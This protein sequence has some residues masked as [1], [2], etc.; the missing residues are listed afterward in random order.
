MVR[1]DLFNVLLPICL[2]IHSL[3][4]P[5]SLANGKPLQHLSFEPYHRHITA[6][7][8]L[9]SSIVHH[10]L[11]D[12]KGLLWFC[13]E[14]GVSK[15]DGNRFT[16]YSVNEGMCSETIIGGSVDNQGDV[17]FFSVENDL[18]Y[19]SQKHDSIVCCSF[20]ER[21]LKQVSSSYMQHIEVQ[22]DTIRFALKGR[23]YGKLVYNRDHDT[24]I[25]MEIW[26]TQA[27]PAVINLGNGHSRIINITT[28]Y[29]DQVS[30]QFAQ[31]AKS[32]GGVLAISSSSWE[33][34]EGY[35]MFAGKLRVAYDKELRVQKVR[36]IQS[37]WVL[38]SYCRDS[39]GRIWAGSYS[40]GAFCYQ[41]ALSDTP[42]T[43]VLTDLTVTGILEDRE[44]GMWFSTY[45]NG[46]YYYPNIPIRYAR[47]AEFELRAF[48]HQMESI[49]Q[50]GVALISTDDGKLFHFQLETPDE[51]RLIFNEPS[52]FSIYP[53]GD[54]DTTIIWT[55]IPRVLNVE[56][57]T[58]SDLKTFFKQRYQTNS[59]YF[60][61]MI[62]DSTGMIW[63]LRVED[64][65]LY[66]DPNRPYY[67]K[68]SE[69]IQELSTVGNLRFCQKATPTS[70][71]L[72]GV[73]GLGYFNAASWTATW[74]D[75]DLP[76][77]K[78]TRIIDITDIG[79]DTVL[80]ATNSA[81]VYLIS[82][83]EAIQRLHK[84][85][86][87]L[88]DQCTSLAYDPITRNGWIGT[89]KGVMQVQ[90]E[91]GQLHLRAEF[92]PKTGYDLLRVKCLAAL[93]SFLLVGTESRIYQINT[94]QLTHPSIVPNLAVLGIQAGEKNLHKEG[95]SYTVPWNQTRITIRYS[96]PVFQNL[97]SHTIRYRVRPLADS[98]T[99]TQQDELT[100]SGLA[101]GSYNIELQA[102]NPNG[103]WS[104]SILPIHLV[105]AAPFWRTPVFYLIV[106]GIALS[107]ISFFVYQRVQFRQKTHMLQLGLINAQNRSLGAQLNPHFLYNVLNSVGANIARGDQKKSL[108]IVGEFARLMRA[109][110]ENSR[111]NLIPLDREL[112]AIR[113]YVELE[114]KRLSNM[115]HFSIHCSVEDTHSVQ[116]PPLLIQPIVENAIWHG[117]LEVDRPGKVEVNI[118]K[119]DDHLKIQVRDNGKGLNPDFQIPKPDHSSGLGVLFDRLRLLDKIY[120]GTF[121]IDLDTDPSGQW[122]TLVT[123]TFPIL[124]SNT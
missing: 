120:P 114:Q 36:T 100:L 16:N 28:S 52:T 81:G 23:G 3:T 31:G 94:H 113:T 88:T 72:A 79:E 27:T 76:S 13:T 1:V 56:N 8:G 119:V 111:Q 123:I 89:P 83:G 122:S 55:A 104:A 78:G 102:L 75:L 46:V 98:W 19:Y 77:G 29:L 26:S 70:Y 110:F 64:G 108:A 80:V 38:E 85:N 48:P 106:A 74:V 35:T 84:G 109:V 24:L 53:I 40:N 99:Q 101:P 10:I 9:P 67:I 20:N 71:Y 7:H 118:A 15:F 96:Q 60:R 42:L 82:Q 59:T 44:G 45:E 68:S 90:Y 107:I 92:T 2:V 25:T 95:G 11:Q 33:E 62:T 49:Q 115:L 116:V 69:P 73:S 17:W 61:S 121:S 21:L 43:H 124:I 47:M 58:F 65:W 12:H 30:D 39:Q 14:N 87:L 4:S 57:T 93:D 37:D 105:I 91:R 22:G 63:H 117:I 51:L 86:G 34:P 97:F 6:E 54:G 5:V 112:D 18:M 66:A 41:T 32:S 103:T 50:S